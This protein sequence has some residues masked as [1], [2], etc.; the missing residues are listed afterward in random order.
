MMQMHDWDAI[1]DYVRPESLKLSCSDS[2]V[3][4]YSYPK[5][6]WNCVAYVELANDHKTLDL[7]S[8]LTPSTLIKLS[9]RHDRVIRDDWLRQCTHLQYLSLPKNK[10]ITKH[11][12]HQLESLSFVNLSFNR[13]MVTKHMLKDGWSRLFL[14][15]YNK[16]PVWIK[17]TLPFGTQAVAV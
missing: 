16:Y 11:T 10:F 15:T 14:H 2:D 8:F 12:I 13:N 1:K 7:S 6:V 17:K 4:M 9:I 3:I 5:E